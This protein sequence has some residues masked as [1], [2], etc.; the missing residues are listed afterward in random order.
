MYEKIFKLTFNLMYLFK[1]KRILFR[2]TKS[3]EAKEIKSL[4]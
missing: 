4:H 3:Y 1:N 2:K